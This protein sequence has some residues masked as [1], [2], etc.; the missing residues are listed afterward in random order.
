M[1]HIVWF[2]RDLRVHDH[3]PLT[4]AA[5]AAAIDGHPV[6]PLYIYE[7][8]VTQ[9]Q[10]FAVQHLGFINESLQSLDR[11]LRKL[12]T[13]LH[14][15]KGEAV[16]VLRELHLTHGIAAL[17]SHEETGNAI[18]YARDLRVGAWAAA[19]AIVW[20]EF[21]QTGVVR[22]LRDRD[23]WSGHWMQRMTAPTLDTPTALRAAPASLAT[24]EL[25]DARGLGLTALAHHAP[26]KPQRQRGGRAAGEDLLDSFLKDRAA[27]YRF[28]MSSPLTATTAC[29]RL[30]PHLAFGTLSIREVVKTAWRRRTALL[31]E[32]STA[33]QQGFLAALKSFESRL[34][35]H[36]HFMQKLE[37]E[38]AIEF[39]NMH[40]GFDGLRDPP[41]PAG[42][43]ATR[44]DA[45]SRG[46]T[47]FPM[48]DASMRMLAATGW[49][50]F[51]MRAMLVSFAAYQLW[52]HW[53][54]PALVLA[55][56][57]LDYEPGIH[58]PQVQMQSGVTGIN[59]IRIYNPLKQASDHD[60][61]GRFVRRWLPA[62]ARVPQTYI[63]EPWTMPPELQ[64]RVG[65]VIDTDY[66]APIVD[67]TQA[68]REARE[69]IHA[70]RAKPEVRHAAQAVYEKHGSRN[71]ARERSPRSSPR[72]SGKNLE[73][74]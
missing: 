61:Q 41:D 33:R 1:L 23:R 58:Y 68:M 6:L 64:R 47:G 8:A 56:E 67:N 31:A 72:V 50:N 19:Q 43:S 53:R 60:P 4:A 71:P 29:S 49:I 51:R 30:S 39:G 17:W 73:L 22:R 36:C 42:G 14:A 7:P 25:P 37:S 57:F 65:C 12:G 34:H 69:R 32:C 55:R 15:R 46:E 26:D 63:F 38:P 5:A 27:D 45:W 21:T 52:L 9:A 20:R 44:L 11:A 3:A 10:D 74:F 18:T 54:G 28:A 40:R 2:K 70:L 59:A 24:G 35:W 13:S 66:P 62:L 48:I 16:E